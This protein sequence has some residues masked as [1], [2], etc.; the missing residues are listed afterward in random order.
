MWQ[1][2]NKASFKKNEYELRFPKVSENLEE[3]KNFIFG[4]CKVC[5]SESTGVHYG[6]RKYKKS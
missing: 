3:K 5:K 6:V 4:K 1:S 2:N